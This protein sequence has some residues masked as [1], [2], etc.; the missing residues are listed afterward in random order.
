MKPVTKVSDVNYMTSVEISPLHEIIELLSDRV[1]QQENARKE[2]NFE[3]FHHT[4]HIIFRFIR[5]NKDPHDHYELPIGSI[6][7]DK[8]LP[9]MKKA[10][11]YY[12]YSNPV[13]P[14]AMLAKLEAG[15]SIDRHVDGAGSNLYTHKIHV[16][17]ITN[18]DVYFYVNDAPYQLLEGMMYE[19]N[20]IKPHG[21]DNRGNSDRVHFIF[22]IFNQDTVCK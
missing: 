7:K 22:E 17:V 21:V 2:N 9:I 10:A 11:E 16:P 1:W 15:Q 6:F 5:G 12:G 4:N 19:V 8:F 18:D 20:N 3:C 14:K 13:F